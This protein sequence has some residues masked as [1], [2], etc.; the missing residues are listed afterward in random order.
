MYKNLTAKESAVMRKAVMSLKAVEERMNQSF[1]TLLKE[2]HN[3]VF[4]GKRIEFCWRHLFIRYIAGTEQVG[5][6]RFIVSNPLTGVTSIYYIKD[7]KKNNA[8]IRWRRLAS[9]IKNT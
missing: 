7:Y 9:A 3:V 8:T 5:N 4:A 6:F 1:E 2:I